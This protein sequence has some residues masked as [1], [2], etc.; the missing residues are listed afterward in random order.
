MNRLNLRGELSF[1]RKLKAAGALGKEADDCIS[2]VINK[3]NQPTDLFFLEGIE[4]IANQS[5]NTHTPNHRN[6]RCNHTLLLGSILSHPMSNNSIIPYPVSLFPTTQ[7]LDDFHV[8]FVVQF[9]SAFSFVL[10]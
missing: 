2:T 8:A 6:K 3:G 4:S 1:V 9:T 5:S 10:H 7:L